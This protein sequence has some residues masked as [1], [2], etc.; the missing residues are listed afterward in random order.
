MSQTHGTSRKTDQQGT[1]QSIYLLSIQ[2]VSAFFNFVSVFTISG[3]TSHRGIAGPPSRA[4]ILGK[5]T[6]PLGGRL[7]SQRVPFETD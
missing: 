2:H 5:A 3:P 7:I 1:L 4:P 6:I